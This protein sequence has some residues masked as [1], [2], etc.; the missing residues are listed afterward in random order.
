MS[1]RDGDGGAGVADVCLVL[2]GTYPYTS[3]GVSTWVHDLIRG[4]PDVRFALAHVAAEPGNQVR[5]YDLPA[6][7]V[8]LTDVYCRQ[9]GGEGA[10]PAALRR[11]ARAERRRHADP[12]RRPLV[13]AALRRLHLDHEVDESLLYD[14]AGADL[15]PAEFLH[16]RS[17]FDLMI[18]L[19]QW[20]APEASLLHFFWHF[21]SMHLPLVRLLRTPPPIASVYHAVCTGYAG[22]L[23]S[24]WSQRTQRPLLLTE[25]GIY[26]RER[27][28]E[29]SRS[30]WFRES[31]EEETSGIDPGAL[32][33]ATATALRRLWA[34]HFRS[35]A[36]CAYRRASAIISLSE[37]GRERQIA[38]GA[39]PWK[40]IVV[41]NGVDIGRLPVP[42]TGGPGGASE[43]VV[44]RVGFVGRLVPIKDVVTFI[45]ACARA[46]RE[47]E[48]DVRLIGPLD[49]D[50]G[51]VRRCR[52]LV[53][54]L[55]L[56]R[57]I[58][59]E[60][61][62]PRERI[63]AAIDL[64]VLTSV[65]EGQP[66]VILEANGAGIPV[67]ATDVGACRELI[68]GR[69]EIDRRIGPGGLVTR[70]AAP[71]DTAAAIVRLVRDPA[72]RRRMGAAGRRRVEA[73]YR[74]R[75]CFQRYESLYENGGWR[76]SAGVSNA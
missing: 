48:I 35:L 53:A 5:R 21:R 73:Y 74:Q 64:L 10:E 25:H 32:D 61:P 18:E 36:R 63:Y 39:P 23:A 55:G 12:R 28:I 45:H 40:S 71:E 49:E 9:P 58:R 54:S 33:E 13:L 67:V 15:S 72:L 43:R 38:D 34:R 1:W 26:T 19:C 2:E 44:P 42:P 20:L 59:F 51:Y 27:V 37:A 62:Q 16:G 69:V 14:L 4:L 68:E 52:R 24:A 29:L 75:D 56:A 66:L 31:G 65:S 70:L 22:F 47:V 60:G 41:P 76:E 46:L 6:N 30:P 3:G 57:R 8:A 17:S 50:P 11:A 7:V